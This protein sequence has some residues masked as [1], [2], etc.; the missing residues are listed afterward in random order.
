[1]TTPDTRPGIPT[2]GPQLT[3]TQVWRQLQ[4]SS[5]AVI[6]YRTPAG[7]PRSS[8][9]LYAAEGRRLYVV[10]ATDS[11]KAR[12]IAVDGRVAVTVPVRRGGLLS[13]LMPIPPA[14]ISFHGR[15]TVRP[16][17]E[18][19]IG[20]L[21]GRVARL[22]P[23]ERRASSTIIEI[24]P[25]GRFATYGIGVSLQRMRHPAAARATVPV[26]DR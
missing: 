22:L 18:P 24:A 1:M 21:P 14:T 10:V 9:V 12:H 13:L 17:G 15:A 16:A 8:G 5:F 4:R 6:S 26:A 11:W 2:R 25:E 23:T 20:A 19:E 7:D 3:A